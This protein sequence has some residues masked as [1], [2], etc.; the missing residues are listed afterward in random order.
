[1]SSH[2]GPQRRFN[3]LPATE[4]LALMRSH[5]VGRVGWNAA[6]GPQILPVTYLLR[7]DTIIFRT[8]PY[9][10]LSELRN[11]HRVAFEVDDFDVDTRTGWTVLVRGMIQAADNPDELA[12]LWTRQEPI[13]WAPGARNLVLAITPDHVTGRVI[14]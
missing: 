10:A 3:A 9:G 6:D 2:D 13:P 7:D 1:M 12:G 14:T 4:C 11:A 8:A 5:T